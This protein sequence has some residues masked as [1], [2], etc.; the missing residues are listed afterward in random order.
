MKTGPFVWTDNAAAAFRQLRKAF[1]IA[2][3]LRH[4]DPSLLIRVEIDTSRF[5][6]VGILN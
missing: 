5:A 2:P 1:I 4:F 6:V 3:I